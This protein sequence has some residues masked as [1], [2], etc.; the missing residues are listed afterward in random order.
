MKKLSI[1]VPVYN[2]ENWLS[3]C[4]SSLINQDLD[5]SEYEII[6]VN[7]GSTDDSFEIAKKYSE[8]YDNIILISQENKG[9][10]AA[11]NAGINKAN[12]KY[13]WFVDSDDWIEPNIAGQLLKEAEDCGLDVLCF[14]LNIAFEDGRSNSFGIKN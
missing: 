7:D 12:G 1:I 2:V 4:A 9:L 14:G 5:K 3:R 8:S 11:R 13:I 10:S 6:F